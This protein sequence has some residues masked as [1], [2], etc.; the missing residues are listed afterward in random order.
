MDDKRQAADIA[1]VTVELQVSVR[2]RHKM[3]SSQPP[4]DQEY[5]EPQTRVTKIEW[6][7]DSRD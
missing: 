1:S 7:T 6:T 2:A 5:D 3:F 4:I